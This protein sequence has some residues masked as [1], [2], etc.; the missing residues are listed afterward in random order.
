MFWSFP[1][2]ATSNFSVPVSGCSGS[3]AR[4]SSSCHSFP[5]IS[6]E[7]ISIFV[8]LLTP[9]IERR[10]NSIRVKSGIPSLSTTVESPVS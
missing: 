3:K 5:T 2:E 1:M 6:M 10:V 7:A 4:T 8:G 9:S